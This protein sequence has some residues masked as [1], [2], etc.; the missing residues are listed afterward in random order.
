M[1]NV[2]TGEV[3]LSYVHLFKP[4]A[5][6]QGAEPKYS[7][8]CLLPKTDIVTKQAL[9][10]AIA[11]ATKK[12]ATD[13]W[14]GVIPPI[15]PTPIHD[16]D[17]VKADGNPYGPECKGHWVFSLSSDRAIQVIDQQGKQLTEVDVYSGC[18]GRVVISVYPY[19]FAGKKGIGFG[20]GPVLKTRDGEP[21]GTTM[22]NAFEAFG[23]QDPNPFAQAQ[24]T[25]QT[26]INPITGL[27]FN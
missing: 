22:P 2:T 5:A 12:G 3:R 17:G 18:Y 1:S 21:L 14:N 9:D 25:P 4:Y 19:A 16:G 13:K 6:M 11:E 26:G 15:L 7:V 24:N 10:A 27:P 20:L 23:I 8:T